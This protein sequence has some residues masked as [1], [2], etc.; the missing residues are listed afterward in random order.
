MAFRFMVLNTPQPGEP[1]LGLHGLCFSLLA[2]SPQAETTLNKGSE[3]TV[4]YPL[5]SGGRHEPGVGALS[6]G[7]LEMGQK[8]VFVAVTNRP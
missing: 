1:G 7:R 6:T 2:A 5:P 8:F 3:R 4:Q